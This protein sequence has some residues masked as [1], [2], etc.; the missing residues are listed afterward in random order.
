MASHQ[1][2][3]P[4]PEVATYDPKD[5]IVPGWVE[6]TPANRAELARYYTAVD[7]LDAEL[8]VVLDLVDRHGLADNTIFVYASDH[9][10]QMPHSKWELYDPGIRLPF[11]VRRPGSVRAGSV[12]DAMISYVDLLPTWMEAAGGRPPEGI[13]G[14]SF[15]GV[16][17]GRADAHRDWV[18]ATHTVDVGPNTGNRYSNFPMRALRTHAHKYILNLTTRSGGLN[19]GTRAARKVEGE[20]VWPREEFY[21][22]RADPYELANAADDPAQK[23]TLDAMR[24]QLREICLAQ[25]DAMPEGLA[26]FPQKP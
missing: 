25:G 8:G 21:D 19:R 22:L 15:L 16:L 13:D 1:P 2:H 17:E 11:I 7:K 18:F 6:D 3:K 24:R 26:P 14:R 23:A 10:I 12:S 5:V 4:W 20:W 9:G